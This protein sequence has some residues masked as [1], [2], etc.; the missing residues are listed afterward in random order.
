[1]WWWVVA[2]IAVAGVAL[3]VYR[4]AERGDVVGG[5]ILMYLCLGALIIEF[6]ALLFLI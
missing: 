5:P 2:A 3:G 1:M 4:V 6:V